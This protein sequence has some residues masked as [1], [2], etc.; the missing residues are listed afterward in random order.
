MDEADT[1]ISGL[2]HE[3]SLEEGEAAAGGGQPRNHLLGD[4]Q[5]QS[6]TAAVAELGSLLLSFVDDPAAI[7]CSQD[8]VGELRQLLPPV[9]R[10]SLS[11]AQYRH[12]ESVLTYAGKRTRGAI[13][14]DPHFSP[15]QVVRTFG[16]TL[17]QTWANKLI[18]GDNLSVLQALRILKREGGLKNADGSDG[19]R[20]CYI[21]PPFATKREFTDKQGVRAYTDR[22][23]GAD[24]IEFLR[25]RL[26]LIHELLADNGV[27][28]VHLDM[29]KAH[30]IKIVLD[31][32]F[33]EH[34]FLNEIV[35]GYKTGGV[36]KRFWPRKHD[37][38]LMY[39]N[40]DEW[41][42]N[43]P[44]K[45]EWYEKPFMNPKSI[46]P[47]PLSEKDK[48][49]VKSAIDRDEPVPDRYRDKLFKRYYA[50]VFVRDVWD[51]DGTKTEASAVS[52]YPT[53]KPIALLN[54]I[55]ETSSNAG[56]LVLDCFS[57]SGSTLRAAEKL[58]RRWVG[59]DVGKLAVHTATRDLLKDM[60]DGGK[61]LASFEV[62]NGGL[63]DEERLLAL[64]FD[65]WRAFVLA[66]FDCH[67][68]PN[69]NVAGV[70]IDGKRGPRNAEKVIVF[71]WA[72]YPGVIIDD[73]ALTS[74]HRALA[75]HIKRG[76]VS[77][78]IPQHLAPT[79]VADAYKSGGLAVRV[80]RVPPSMTTLALEG[81]VDGFAELSQ[82]ASE[83]RV[84]DAVRS[85]GFDFVLPPLL[86]KKLSVVN[87]KPCVTLTRFE[88]DA[89]RSERTTVPTDGRDDLAM[90]LIDYDHIDFDSNFDFETVLWARK[91]D[92]PGKAGRQA[93]SQATP[94]WSFTLDSKVLTNRVAITWIDR[95][96]N[97]LR[98]VIVPDQWQAG[99]R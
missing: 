36:S 63:Y 73:V 28:Y 70:A 18:F 64:P 6:P 16:S 68:T 71:D 22:V 66:L 46:T 56:D 76:V 51:H 89:R 69:V 60:R 95:F 39:A 34:R 91:D 45:R 83:G 5:A 15:L 85:A 87:G 65:D 35:W 41:V 2:T 82:P 42:H 17:D 4:H 32:V 96:G 26:Y 86:T 1:A 55:I 29:K 79:L 81:A 38:I 57:G 30:Y 67:P 72:A 90:V 84:N 50:D 19:F 97:E 33:G 49:A 44:K 98:E 7:A 61:P 37:T 92:G 80:L 24:F 23:E 93:L 43:P 48:E 40:S 52:G 8:R 10:E 11:T 9:L 25:Q 99:E 58:G 54:R 14:S 94:K 74:L 3:Q 12:G 21:D 88:A 78:I 27:L 75:G 59:V 53:Q 20:L 31:E 77:V 47:I 62:L 13:L